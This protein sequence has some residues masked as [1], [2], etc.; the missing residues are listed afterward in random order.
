MNF[1]KTSRYDH[2]SHFQPIYTIW[3]GEITNLYLFAICKQI[4]FKKKKKTMDMLLLNVV[5]TF[6]I[7]LVVLM[8]SPKL[9]IEFAHA[10]SHYIKPSI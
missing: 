3:G 2:L 7:S 5:T 1:H 9:H 10:T 8:I 4:K 6:L